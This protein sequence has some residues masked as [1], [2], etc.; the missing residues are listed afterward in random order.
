MSSVFSDATII[1]ELRSMLRVN[2]LLPLA[3]NVRIPPLRFTFPFPPSQDYHLDMLDQG[4]GGTEPPGR[5]V[6][7]EISRHS[8]SDISSCIDPSVMYRDMLYRVRFFTT[9]GAGFAS[10]NR[11]LGLAC[12]CTHKRL[13][14]LQNTPEEDQTYN[15][16][17]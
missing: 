17:N 7:L 14:F 1:E 5:E 6:F 15:K 13:F 2:E 12:V 10:R 16:I 4:K 8:T 9:R 11:T 3:P